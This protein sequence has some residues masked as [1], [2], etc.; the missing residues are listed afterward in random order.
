[1]RMRL[2]PIPLYN[3]TLGNFERDDRYQVAVLRPI[4]FKL[5]QRQRGLRVK[6]VELRRDALAVADFGEAQGLFRELQRLFGGPQAAQACFYVGPGGLNL[7]FYVE[8]F[9]LEGD[10][11]LFAYCACR[12][13]GAACH[14]A[15]EDGDR[16]ADFRAP[17]VAAAVLLPVGV[18]PAA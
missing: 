4:V 5:R 10:L 17:A 6:Q 16:K 18:G 11:I 2:L 13:H 8:S 7:G 1:M 3:G 15:V 14:I 12:D 9:L